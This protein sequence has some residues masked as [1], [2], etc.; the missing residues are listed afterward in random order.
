MSA[1]PPGDGMHTVIVNGEEFT[2]STRYSNLAYIA[3]GAYGMVCTADDAVRA[4]MLSSG[5]SQP[6][7]VMLA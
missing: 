5:A 1:A 3:R 6:P 4:R 7:L 2:V